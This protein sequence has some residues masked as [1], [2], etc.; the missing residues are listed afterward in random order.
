MLLVLRL[1]Q[2]YTLKRFQPKKDLLIGNY[3]RSS[4]KKYLFNAYLFCLSLQ[5][6]EEP[7][8]EAGKEVRCVKR[9]ISVVGNAL[10]LLLTDS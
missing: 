2:V 3:T 6:Q 5:T 10:V 9:S 1:L 8:G 7:R 4:E